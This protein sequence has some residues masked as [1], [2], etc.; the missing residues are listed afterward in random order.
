MTTTAH[1]TISI[2]TPPDGHDISVR[3]ERERERK[4]ERER[5]RER[6][7]DI[8]TETETE[9]LNTYPYIYSSGIL[10]PPT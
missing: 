5:E 10:A 2:Q 1:C 9:F 3:R 7:R 4:R 6:E 8:Q